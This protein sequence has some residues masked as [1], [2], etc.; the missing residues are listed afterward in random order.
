MNITEIDSVHLDKIRICQECEDKNLTTRSKWCSEKCYQRSI[1]KIK[2]NNK[3]RICQQCGKPHNLKKSIKFCSKECSYKK[4]RDTQNKKKRDEVRIRRGLDLN[5][6]RLIREKGKGHYCSKRGYIIVSKKGHPN[7]RNK[8]GSIYQH[9]LVMSN[10][11]G[12]PLIKGENVHHKNGIRS[13]NRIENLELWSRSQPPGQ[14]VEDK[15]KWCKEFL[16]QYPDM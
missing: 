12:R 4:I 11:L 14:R 7:S 13:D 15:I 9:I 3:I 8:S 6:P 5:H 2:F 10:H 16:A 1:E